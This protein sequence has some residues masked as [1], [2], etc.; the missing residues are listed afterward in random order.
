MSAPDQPPDAPSLMRVREV[1]AL[2]RLSPRTVWR[3]AAAGGDFP[4][5]AAL[6]GRAKVWR[7]RDVLANVDRQPRPPAR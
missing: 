1:A 7:R 6:G 2:L 4:R 3:L 5:P